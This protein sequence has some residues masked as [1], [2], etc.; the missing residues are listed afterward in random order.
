MDPNASPNRILPPVFRLWCLIALAFLV[1]AALHATTQDGPLRMEII[2]A[3]NLVVDSNIE[4]PA[5]R[6][7]SAAHMGVR[8][9]NDGPDALTNVRVNIGSLIDQVNGT[10]TPGVFR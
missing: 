10:G 8:I 3:P 6:S 1:P 4:S 5:G 9:Y 2:A 7:P